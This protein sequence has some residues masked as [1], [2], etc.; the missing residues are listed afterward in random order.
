MPQAPSRIIPRG[1]VAAEV[2]PARL[3]TGSGRMH[4]KRRKL[5][6][7]SVLMLRDRPGGTVRLQEAFDIPADQISGGILTVEADDENFNT[8][9]ADF[10]IK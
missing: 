1:E 3:T 5:K 6:Q 8:V 7:V 9:Y 4:H 10:P 2:R